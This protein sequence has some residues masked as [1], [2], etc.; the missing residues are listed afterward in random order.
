[1]G[2]GEREVVTRRF[3]GGDCS[4]CGG[5]KVVREVVCACLLARL[6]ASKTGFQTARNTQLRRKQ[7][8]TNGRFGETKGIG[9]FSFFSFNVTVC[10]SLDSFLN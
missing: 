8:E 5:G 4:D 6:S 7:K 1:V 9:F 3:G 2:V 10:V